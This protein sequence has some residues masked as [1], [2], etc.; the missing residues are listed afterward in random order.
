MQAE[1][2]LGDE[3]VAQGAID[4]GLVGAFAYPGT[5]STEIFEHIER[6]A[7]EYGVAARWSANEKVAYEEAL[8][9][10]YAGRRALISMK[11]VGLNVA[12][13]PFMSSALT[14]VNGG[15]VLVV[16]DD[17][18]MH[19][20]QNEQD[21]RFYGDFAKLPLFEPATQQEAY[22]FTREAF[23]YSERIGLPV[24]IRIVTR[25]AHSR[26]DVRRA[27]PTPQAP[28]PDVVLPDT[29]RWVLVPSHARKRYQHLLDV[30]E[31]IVEDA[32]R[33]PHN[34]LRLEGPRGIIAAGVARN[35]VAEVLGDDLGEHSLL[36]IGMYPLPV[37]LLREL[38]DHTDEIYVFEDGYPFI[39]RQLKG[40]L[41]LKGK[42]IHGRLDGALP[43][44]GELSPDIVAQALYP[45][46]LLPA[47]PS[48]TLSARPPQLC[49]GCPHA[50][51]FRA[52]VEATAEAASP[53]LLSDIGC[54]SLGVMAPYRAI[55]TVVDMGASIGMASGAAQAGAHPVVCTIGDSTFAH[56][57][58]PALLAAAYYDHNMTVVI[59]DNS[60]VAM[61][62]IQDS[63]LGGDRLVAAV[64]GLGVHPE[65]CHVIEPHPK[66]HAD[67]VALFRREIEHRGL[68]VIIAQRACIH[69]NAKLKK[70][71]AA[72]GE[73]IEEA[74]R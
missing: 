58:L 46:R 40:L 20:S 15:L 12:A 71:A 70:R 49:R 8:G 35:Y 29:D 37:G 54:Y 4:A 61:T 3:A 33:S 26:A 19:S 18:G 62:G 1:L 48:D 39:E 9:M 69:V 60:A 44:A 41:G 34:R 52:I 55:H 47:V 57:G 59:L 38:V 22:D 73:T 74:T 66:H 63:L 17:P 23:E 14:G 64:I 72:A 31:A 56:S 25:L 45:N 30:Q 16:A 13:D 53:M 28:A 6:H 21:T 11:H 67:N 27:E 51:S 24:I 32:S 5:P 7:A 43:P 68:S 50:D 65:H 36:E 42:A 10:S 2:F